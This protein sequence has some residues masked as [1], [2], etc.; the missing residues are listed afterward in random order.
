MQ[1]HGRNLSSFDLPTG[2][3]MAARAMLR[4]STSDVAGACQTFVYIALS[5]QVP[6]S[7]ATVSP[8]EAPVPCLRKRCLLWFCA[9]GP[10]LEGALL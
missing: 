3:A 4:S 5:M 6:G 10:A 1:M 7:C 2:G 9:G 8:A